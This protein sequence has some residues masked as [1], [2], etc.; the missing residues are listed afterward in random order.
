MRHKQTYIAVYEQSKTSLS[1]MDTKKWISPDEMKLNASIWGL[2]HKAHEM[3]ACSN[4]LFDGWVEVR[5]LLA[6]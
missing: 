1:P 4:E 2:S 6:P 3:D 5:C